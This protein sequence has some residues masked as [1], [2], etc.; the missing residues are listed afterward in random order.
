[1]LFC[2][3]QRAHPEQQK[4]ETES[5][6]NS[7][8]DYFN[9]QYFQLRVYDTN[10]YKLVIALLVSSVCTNYT[11]LSLLFFSINKRSTNVKQAS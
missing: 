10:F 11:I 5:A 6:P 8:R 4:S 9:F 1:M 7:G 2:G 3:A